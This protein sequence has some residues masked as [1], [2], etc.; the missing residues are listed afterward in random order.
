M[1]AAASLNSKPAPPTHVAII[2][3]GNGRW[4]KSRGLPRIAG[5]RQGADVVRSTVERCGRLGV[6]FLTIYAFSSEN[7]KRP[8]DEVD[9]LMGLLSLYL[10]REL[11]K[12]VSAG[13]CMRFIGE[14]DGLSPNIIELIEQAEA[15]TRDNSDLTL[16]VALN[17]GGRREIVRA[18]RSLARAVERGDM[19]PGDIDEARFTGMLDTAGVPDPD[20]LIRTSGEQRLSN[21]LPWQS[22]YTELVFIPVLW[23]DFTDSHLD[24]AISEFHRRERRYGGAGG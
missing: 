4:A 8:S 12:L 3:D 14:R 5:H 1:E 24:E 10:Q 18:A 20:L 22:A 19:A 23:P 7:W 2:M 11:G 15:S 6:S 17:Y 21:F 9:D 16:V 13:V